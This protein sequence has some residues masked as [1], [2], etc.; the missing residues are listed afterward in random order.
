VA[1]VFSAALAAAG[2]FALTAGRF[3]IVWREAGRVV[4]GFFVTALVRVTAF[5]AAIFLSETALAG[6]L[7]EV[8]AVEALRA[9][10]REVWAV[11]LSFVLPATALVVFSPAVFG[12]VVAVAGRDTLTSPR[13]G[14]SRFRAF[15]A[16]AF[17][18]GRRVD[19]L[20]E[21]EAMGTTLGTVETW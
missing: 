6:F 20:R 21:V 10:V 5:L 12:L 9:G 7:G 3:G 2:L 19:L 4:A 17:I 18:D 8:L 14:R 16:V 15:A 11:A 1:A 13:M